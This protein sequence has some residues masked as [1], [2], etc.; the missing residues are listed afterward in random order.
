MRR[1]ICASSGGAVYGD[2]AVIPTP[3][4]HPTFPAS[5]YG[6]SKLAMEHYVRYWSAASGISTIS[7][8][9]A[10]VYG[11]RQNPLGEA[12]VV[13][14]FAHR[15][16]RGE[17][18]IVNGDGLQTRD[19]VY[20]EDVAAANLLALERAEVTG[21]FNIGTGVETSVLDLLE[22][23]QRVAGVGGRARHRPPQ[24]GE[25]RR[26]ALDAS[27]A[28]EQLGWVP[29]VSL[30]EGLRLTVDRMRGEARP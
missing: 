5:P 2:A 9:Y 14:I 3:E 24:P 21:V 17:P 12:G 15:L 16:L 8:R 7:L 11:P 28:R 4:G 22:R 20:V 19:Y 6:I 18:A 1:V 29:H 23:L 26:S 13:A 25:Q 30:D 10:N 27:L